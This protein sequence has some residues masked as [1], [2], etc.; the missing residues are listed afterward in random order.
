MFCWDTKGIPF[1]LGWA[2]SACNSHAGLNSPFLSISYSPMMQLRYVT[3][4]L[5]F[6]SSSPF[7][8]LLCPTSQLWLQL[9]FLQFLCSSTFLLF[10]TFFQEFEFLHLFLKPAF[11]HSLFCFVWGLFCL[12]FLISLCVPPFCFPPILSF[13]FTHSS[14]SWVEL[15]FPFSQTFFMFPPPASI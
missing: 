15:N 4:H 6:Y 14:W 10:F 11:L 13:Y 1:W 12:A 2:D 3:G 8:N 5:S 7:L 9:P